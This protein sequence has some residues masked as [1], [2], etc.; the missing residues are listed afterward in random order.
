MFVLSC[1]SAAMPFWLDAIAVALHTPAEHVLSHTCPQLPQF[2]ESES[3]LIDGWFEQQLGGGVLPAAPAAP[4]V[5]L[6]A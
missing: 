3:Q 4:A 2:L 6:P 5:S 1:A